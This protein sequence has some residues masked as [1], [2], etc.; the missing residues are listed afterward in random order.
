MNDLK[1]AAQ[2]RVA[3]SYTLACAAGFKA[4]LKKEAGD[5]TAGFQAIHLVA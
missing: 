1:P 5:S 4:V 2:A 3:A